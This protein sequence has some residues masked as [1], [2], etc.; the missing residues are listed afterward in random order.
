MTTFILCFH[1]I[2]IFLQLFHLLILQIL[3]Y[4]LPKLPMQEWTVSKK[5]GRRRLPLASLFRQIVSH[6]AFVIITIAII[7]QHQDIDAFYMTQEVHNMFL[8]P[9]KE[10]TE[11]SFMRK[12]FF[13]FLWLCVQVVSF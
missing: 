5:T 11:V 7:L 2:L 8:G 3:N 13:P 9:E 6:V 10:F 1:F 4:N 12:V